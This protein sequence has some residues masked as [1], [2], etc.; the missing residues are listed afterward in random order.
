MRE[1][2][3]SRLVPEAVAGGL[4]DNSVFGVVI[5]EA[6]PAVPL[7]GYADLLID[8]LPLEGKV[9]EKRE[10]VKFAGTDAVRFVVT[11]AVGGTRC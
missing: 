11:G 9:T 4:R 3:A 5:V 1:R 8:L 6:A 2:D 7:D 10:R